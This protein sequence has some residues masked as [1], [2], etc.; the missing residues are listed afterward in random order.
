[1]SP[2]GAAQIVSYPPR[3]TGVHLRHEREESDMR[4]VLEVGVRDAGEH[5]A[6][7]IRVEQDELVLVD[8]RLV[9]S[10]EPPIE[11]GLGVAL[12]VLR[13]QALAGFAKEAKRGR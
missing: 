7:T 5:R 2:G 8:L 11:A 1:M 13:E 4:L 3:T 12:K 6:Y 10:G 9:G